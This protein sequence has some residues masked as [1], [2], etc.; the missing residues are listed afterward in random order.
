MT[1]GYAPLSLQ[2]SVKNRRY[3]RIIVAILVT[4]IVIMMTNVAFLTLFAYITEYIYKAL[5]NPQKFF[6]IDKIFHSVSEKDLEKLISGMSYLIKKSSV[7]DIIAFFE[8]IEYCLEN[9]CENSR[10]IF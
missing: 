6:N 5:E 9:T 10:G 4:N 8:S 1:N 2:Y 3:T 7:Q